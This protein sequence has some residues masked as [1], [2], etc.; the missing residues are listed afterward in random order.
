MNW[1]TKRFSLVCYFSADVCSW[2]LSEPNASGGEYTLLRARHVY[3]LLLPLSV[4]LDVYSGNVKLYDEAIYFFFKFNEID[5][6][7]GLS[8]S[9]WSLI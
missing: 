4:F 2:C 3:P 6:L 8:S 5:F 9:P 1:R 7:S